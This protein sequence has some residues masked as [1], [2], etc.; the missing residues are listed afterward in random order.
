MQEGAAELLESGQLLLAAVI[1]PADADDAAAASAEDDSVD[2]E[3]WAEAEFASAASEVWLDSDFSPAASETGADAES[4]ASEACTDEAAAS[5]LAA[6]DRGPAHAQ[7][8]SAR[9]AQKTID[10]VF[11]NM[12]LLSSRS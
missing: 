5:S 7:S 1:A 3:A 6:E 11:L 12:R 9:I 10:K 4:F 8:E 2:P